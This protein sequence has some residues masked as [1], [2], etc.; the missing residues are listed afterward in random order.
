MDGHLRLFSPSS[1]CPGC[2]LKE[3]CGAAL[4][5]HACPETWSP[6][7]PGGDPVSH[8]LKPGTMEELKDVNGPEFDDIVARPAPRLEL[9]LY[10]AQ[11]RYRTS[12]RGHLDEPVYFIRAT[13][14]I[15]SKQVTSAGE[16]RRDLGLKQDQ[17]LIVLLF[18]DDELLESMWTRGA[19]LVRELVDTGYDAV[20]SPSFSTY[21]PRPR[22]DFLINAKRSLLYFEALQ[23][24]GAYAIPRIA[25]TVS[26]DARRM[27]NWTRENPSIETVALDLSTY[28]PPADWRNQL[29]GLDIF[30]SMT[31]KRISYLVNGPTTQ[32]RCEQLYEIAG[33]DRVRITTATTQAQIPARSLRSTGDQ[34]GP[35]FKA[36][37]AA[38]R[39]I[40]NAA[41]QKFGEARRRAA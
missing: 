3:T 38:Q 30:D 25:W 19:T 40:V 16:I 41:A 6:E 21:T 15:K 18:D 1:I 14:V 36:R 24:A 4:T 29:E 27:A 26:H 34:T 28:R 12:L 2:P 37:L 31:G 33:A 11:I 7:R 35:T 17:R 9:P 8:P 22:T 10:T 5:D 39:R 13:G 20:V 32:E 23:I